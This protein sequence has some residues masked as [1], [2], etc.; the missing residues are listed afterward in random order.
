MIDDAAPVVTAGALG[1]VLKTASEPWLV[2]PAFVA[3]TL[4]W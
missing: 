4:K 2:P 1:S 3:V